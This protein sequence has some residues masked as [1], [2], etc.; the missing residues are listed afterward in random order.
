[1]LKNKIFFFLAFFLS[2]AFVSFAQL[3]KKPLNKK[4]TPN[5]TSD[6][7]VFDEDKS[8]DI[9]DV[10]S[11]VNVYNTLKINLLGVVAGDVA[12]YYE[13]VLSP[14]FSVETGLGITLPTLKVGKYLKD[15]GYLG[16]DYGEQVVLDKANTSPFA[17]LAFRYFPSKR[18]RDIPEG[19]Y[20]SLGTQWRK[21]SF[22]T[23]LDNESAPFLPQKSI[24]QHF[25]YL[26]IT[27]GKSKMNDR[28]ISDYYVG[29]ALR[30]TIKS[31][32]L[33]DIANNYEITPYRVPSLAPSIVIGYKLGFGF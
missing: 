33:Y 2:T 14:H 21:Y 3:K 22:N 8:G 24:T 17:S 27:I 16:L 1:M 9:F 15:S 4:A 29:L 25:D 11:S 30:N 26:R 7:Q 19:I 6:V 5:K 31:S 32:Y 28:F 10:K 18:E 23:H 20:F 12:L 13:R